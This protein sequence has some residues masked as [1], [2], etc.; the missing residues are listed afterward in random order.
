VE[1]LSGSE[2]LITPRDIV[3]AMS[4]LYAVRSP[5]IEPGVVEGQRSIQA[6]FAKF[7]LGQR[8]VV[9]SKDIFL[10]DPASLV[11]PMQT[12]LPLVPFKDE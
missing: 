5:Q 11:G 10:R 7:A 2:A 8:D 9:E 1:L 4:T 12:K 6:L 3:D